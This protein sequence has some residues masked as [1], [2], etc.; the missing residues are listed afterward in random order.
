MTGHIPQ[1]QPV[2]AIEALCEPPQMLGES[3]GG[4]ML[5]IPII[6]GTVS[7]S[8]LNGTVLSGGADWAT[9]YPDR[10]VVD[11]RYAIRAD[12]GT[13][14]QVFNGGTVLIGAGGERPGVAFTTPRFVAPDGPHGWLNHGVFVGTLIADPA[15]MGAVH[16]N[17]F[18]MS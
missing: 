9:V 12:D 2:F 10:A 7:G 1:A 5:M 8:A 16:I 14:I 4:R 18:K 17:I 15:N 11:A 6:G 13:V 3:G